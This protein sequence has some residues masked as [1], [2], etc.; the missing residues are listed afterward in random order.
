MTHLARADERDSDA[1]PRQLQCFRTLTQPLEM[2]MSIANSAGILGW[3]AS[4]AQW[5][6]PGLALYGV[7]PFPGTTG[8]QL[9]L[10][11]AMRFETAVIAIRELGSGETVGYGG[12]LARAAAL[13]HRDSRRRVRRWAAAKPRQRDAGADRRAARRAGRSR[14][15]GYVCGRCDRTAPAS[16]SARALL[17]GP[18]LPVE[19]IAACARTIPYEL[20][21]GVRQ[22]VAH[23]ALRSARAAVALKPRRSPSSRRPA[24]PRRCPGA[25]APARR[26]RCR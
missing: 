12:R 15:D 7:S 14:I 19:Q 16:S 8:A 26:L 23:E 5:A 9:G 20:L 11:P 10:T 18:E 3:E 25:C 2:P 21:C 22:R 24:A 1:T 4:R 6:R 13:A 17:W